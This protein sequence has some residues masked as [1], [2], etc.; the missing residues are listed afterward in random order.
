M[1]RI[2]YVIVLYQ[3]RW[4]ITLNGT[5]YGPYA[6]QAQAIEA[7]RAA[8]KKVRNSQVLVQGADNLFRTEW[9]YGNDPY[10]PAG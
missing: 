2:Q 5:R 9:T 7:A 10:P 1:S 6:T 4:H 8:A 3:G